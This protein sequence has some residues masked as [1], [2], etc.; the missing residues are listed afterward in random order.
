V[1]LSSDLGAAYSA[2][3][4]AVLARS[5]DPGRCVELTHELRPHDIAEAAFVVR[6]MAAGFPPRTV[7]VVVVDPGVGGGRVPIAISCRDGSVLIGPDN[8]VLAPL[9]ERLGRPKGYRID[10]RR[11]AG[12]ERV[13][14]T[15]DGRDV[16]A[17]AAALVALGT[18]ASRLG[19]ARAPTP[20]SLPVPRRVLGGG[21]GEVAH[22]D[23]FGNLITN[24]PTHWVPRG[25]AR[26][27]VQLGS[28]SLP[29]P[30]V[31]SYDS[32]GRGRSGALGS[33][34]GTV[35]ISV[36]RGRAD[37]RYGARTGTG[38]AVRGVRGAAG[39]G[40]SVNSHPSRRR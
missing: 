11:L 37:R 5:L 34:F 15:F 1:T 23:H 21:A 4:K 27:R 28:R 19:P 33:S 29:L 13:G 39:S 8:G 22:V 2:Q 9:A 38:A 17:P 10:A 30:W 32:L 36:D 20:Y 14:T 6:A 24:I 35:E 26:V 12:S 31:D 3:M 16:F 40:Q 7:H 25:T 18:P